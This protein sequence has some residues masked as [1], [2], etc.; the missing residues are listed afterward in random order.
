MKHLRQYIRQILLA[1]S[2]KSS[3]AFPEDLA[4]VIKQYDYEYI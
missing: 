4:I 2:A 3:N 1:E